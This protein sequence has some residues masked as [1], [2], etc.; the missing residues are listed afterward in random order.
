LPRR[1]LLPGTIRP[2]A[3]AI[4]FDAMAAEIASDSAAT[5]Q[6]RKAPI[7][8]PSAATCA[9]STSGSE[10]SASP[11]QRPE[12]SLSAQVLFGDHLGLELYSMPG[13]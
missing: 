13:V 5:C 6:A 2:L 12:N 3:V 1:L 4:Q 10:A 8:K 9:L 11:G 7:E